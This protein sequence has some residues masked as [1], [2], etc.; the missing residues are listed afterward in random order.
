[1]N[2]KKEM[3]FVGKKISWETSKGICYG[4]INN[5]CY[6]DYFEVKLDENSEKIMSELYRYCAIVYTP[7]NS[8]WI[9]VDLE[10]SYYG[11][12]EYKIVFEK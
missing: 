10:D 7:E 12:P 9:E 11:S 6:D 3:D 2:K 8:N 5:K 1:M 4:T